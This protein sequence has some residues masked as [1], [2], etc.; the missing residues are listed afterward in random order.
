MSCLS[1]LLRCCCGMSML[2]M[3][4]PGILS[5][6]HS[7]ANFESLRVYLEV[8]L[9]FIRYTLCCCEKSS[10]SW[11]GSFCRCHCQNGEP[12]NFSSA[13]LWPCMEPLLCLQECKLLLGTF[14]VTIDTVTT[15][16]CSLPG[17]QADLTRGLTT[18]E[19]DRRDF[20]L[21]VMLHLDWCV[22]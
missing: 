12:P 8:C 19:P 15:D 9:W 3:I 20:L 7:S 10:T 2:L 21:K 11:K 17:R 1:F 13:Y 14:P 6:L 4:K 18:K 16:A 5:A 22:S